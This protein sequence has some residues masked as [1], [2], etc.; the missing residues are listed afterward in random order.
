MP[1]NLPYLT[2]EFPPIAA[3]IRRHLDDF[4]VDELPAYDPCGSGDHVYVWIE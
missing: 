2:V 4:Q 1:S 3:S